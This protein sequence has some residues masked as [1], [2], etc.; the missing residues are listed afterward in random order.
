MAKTLIGNIKGPQGEIGPQGIQGIQGV[1]GETGATGPQGPQG[2]TGPQGLQG[3]Q[4]IQGPAG[5]RG[6]RWFTG[7][8]CTGMSTSGSIFTGICDVDNIRDFYIDDYYLNTE[9][10]YY[11]RC[12]EE[13]SG[14]NGYYGGWAYVGKLTSS[15]T[16]KIPVYELSDWTYSSDNSNSSIPEIVAATVDENGKFYFFPTDSS[17]YY[18]LDSF[19]GYNEYSPVGG[20]QIPH[21]AT[22]TCAACHNNILF[23]GCIGVIYMSVDGGDTWSYGYKYV[24]GTVNNIR[25]YNDLVIATTSDNEIIIYD[26]QNGVWSA[27]TMNLDASGIYDITYANGE[28]AITT[29]CGIYTTIDF[30]TYKRVNPLV[31]GHVSYV[32]G[33]YIMGDVET[34]LFYSYDLKHVHPC[35]SD[36]D[37]S[38]EELKFRDVI[39]HNGWFLALQYCSAY[40]WKSKDGIT[41]TETLPDGGSVNFNTITPYKD[42][43]L[44]AGNGRF[45]WVYR[46]DFN[47][48]GNIEKNNALESLSHA[49]S[50]TNAGMVKLFEKTDIITELETMIK[51]L[52]SYTTIHLS[53]LPWTAG[54]GA[55]SNILRSVT[56]GNGKFVAVGNSGATYYSSDGINW[57]AGSGTESNTL[58]SV[59]YGNGKFVTVGRGDEAGYISYSEDGVTWSSGSEYGDYNFYS[60]TYGNNKFVAVGDTG[61]IY[62]SLTGTNWFSS[63]EPDE[64][65]LN[66]V[67]YANDKFV[68][69]GASGYTCYSSDGIN[70]TDGGNIGSNTLNSV[71]YGNE[72]L[73]AVGNSG[74]TYYSSDGINWTAGSG[75]GSDTLYSV[76]YT[77]GKFVAVG[78]SGA[79]YYSSDGINWTAG[80][81]AGSNN[82]RSVTYENG[83]FVA[84]GNSGS[85]YYKTIGGI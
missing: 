50:L 20:E 80:S 11:Y 81:G 18:T 12:V 4:G 67:T 26:A 84:V 65:D 76:V 77:N 22:V 75:A 2:E 9:T 69:V 7:T 37:I 56:Y 73:V 40:I 82:L 74:A 63:N 14:R 35:I 46:A 61:V 15:D 30:E 13:P 3:I 60:V 39:Y 32:D 85:T 83:K 59:A 33:L 6:S 17:T 23:V 52:Q 78:N 21:Y 44:V 55:G 19:T 24:N 36:S 64:I 51:N 10:G 71:T 54:N 68:A 5:Q 53:Q 38:L 62:Y 42:M 41:W 28:Y 27:Y 8:S 43:I 47:T 79:T 34:G 45:C 66:S 70:W 49:I 16:L 57:T 29:A 25:A 58:Y 72:I 48:V 31:M 1:P